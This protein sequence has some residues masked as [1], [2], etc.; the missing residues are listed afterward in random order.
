MPGRTSSS[1]ILQYVGVIAAIV[2]VIGY[3]VSGWQF[4]EIDS[5]IAFA[6]GVICVSIAE[7]WELYRRVA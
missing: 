6:L 3:V 4:G 1:N 5:T 2:G 7:C